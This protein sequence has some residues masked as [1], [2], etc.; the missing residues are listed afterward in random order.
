VTGSIA[1]PPLARSYALHLTKSLGIR[2]LTQQQSCPHSASLITRSNTSIAQSLTAASTYS[3][4]M[5][6]LTTIITATKSTARYRLHRTLLSRHPFCDPA[7][8]HLSYSARRIYRCTRNAY[9]S[10]EHNNKKPQTR[11]LR[12]TG[13]ILLVAIHSSSKL[14]PQEDPGLRDYESYSKTMMNHISSTAA[15]TS[16][17]TCRTATSRLPY[18][19]SRS[20]RHHVFDTLLHL[21]GPLRP[22]ARS[23]WWFGGTRF[24]ARSKPW[25]C[26]EENTQCAKNPNYTMYKEAVNRI[27]QG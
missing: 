9:R 11:S 13:Q 7:P 24:E 1:H 23:S 6:T 19:T 3:S 5:I 18:P 26:F 16:S 15:A 4:P 2:Y 17:A 21:M 20:N 27:A 10:R 25:G 12:S 8:N 14:Y 22:P